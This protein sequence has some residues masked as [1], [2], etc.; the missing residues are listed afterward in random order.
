MHYAIIIIIII[1]IIIAIII[2]G[3]ITII[4]E[5][6]Q[7]FILRS[8]ILGKQQIDQLNDVWKSF[9]SVLGMKREVNLFCKMKQLN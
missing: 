2:T 8:N 6:P 3:C 5:R 7:E 9:T 4:T 1:I